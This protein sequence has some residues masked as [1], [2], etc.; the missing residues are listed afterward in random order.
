VSTVA[1]MIDVP[2]GAFP[3]SPEYLVEVISTAALSCRVMA[4]REGLV[5]CSDLDV[6]CMAV[7]YD[8]GRESRGSVRETLGEAEADAR[9]LDVNR[10]SAFN[11]RVRFLVTNSVRGE[12]TTCLTMT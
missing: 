8:R 1:Y 9:S 6:K 12:M 4:E 7:T 3:L 11:T 5:A 10:R 2:I